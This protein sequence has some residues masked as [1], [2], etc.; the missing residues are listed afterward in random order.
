VT[1]AAAV[2]TDT[3]LPVA[4]TSNGYVPEGLLSTPL[5][6]ERYV[7]VAGRSLTERS[8]ALGSQALVAHDFLVVSPAVPSFDGG[9]HVA[10]RAG[11]RP[12][13]CCRSSCPDGHR[14]GVSGIA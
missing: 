9:R 7:C 13:L 14:C 3:A 2:A 12:P 6:T 5:F 10:A 1:A 4:F 11:A 8:A